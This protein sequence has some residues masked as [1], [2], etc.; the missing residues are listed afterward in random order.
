MPCRGPPPE[1]CFPAT[2]V[3]V[4][5][6][7]WKAPMSIGL[8]SGNPRWSVVMPLPVPAPIAGSPGNRGMVSVGPP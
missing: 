4:K 7:L 1:A 8:S 3:T 5:P 6:W 2:G